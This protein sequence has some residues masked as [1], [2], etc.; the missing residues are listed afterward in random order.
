VYFVKKNSTE[1]KKIFIKTLKSK[2]LL[3]FPGAYSPL[4]AKLIEETGFEGVYVSGAVV[5]NDLGLPD[6][7]L[8]TLSEVSSRAE[9]ISRV[10]NLPTIVDADTG[11]GETMNCARTIETLENIGACGC[12][13]E[14]QINPKRCG[15]LDN[16]EIIA[17]G[18]MIKKIKSAVK[19][20]KDK[21]FLVIARTDANTIEGLKKTIYRIKAYV[22]AGADMIFPEA[23]KNEKE[24]E[25]VRKCTNA[26]I[27]ANMTE[28]GKS[29]LLTT[30]QLKNLGLNMVI[31]P[32]TIQ[33]LAMK[34]VEDGL[35]KIFKNGHQKDLLKIMQTRKRLYELVNYKR[36]SEF[37][38]NIFNFSKKGHE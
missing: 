27:L 14:D 18:D 32:V 29:K 30:K 38:K 1:K 25:E 4:V 36:Y 35:K 6:I 10:T 37:D 22:D 24:F 8:T 7:G 2:K 21:N 17:V 11:F 12:H 16:K 3:R 34:S 23:M 5:A 9:Q 31:Y 26:Y 28:F 13:I 20:K 19:A 33:R 15:H